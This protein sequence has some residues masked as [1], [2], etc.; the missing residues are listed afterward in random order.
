MK[1][2]AV[3]KYYNR[4]AKYKKGP[5]CEGITLTNKYY[6][7]L[8]KRTY[9]HLTTYYR[10]SGLKYDFKYYS[11]IHKTNYDDGYGYNY[12]YGDYGYYEQTSNEIPQ[13]PLIKFVIIF[14]V[15]FILICCCFTFWKG[16]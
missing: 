5:C 1:R 13:N 2:Y 4:R 15:A 6:S 3:P 10:P 16:I 14:G 12:Y 7:I 11:K 9:Y 8:K